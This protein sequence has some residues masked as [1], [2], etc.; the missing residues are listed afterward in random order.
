MD[1]LILAAGKGTRMKN[2][3]SKVLFDIAGRPM[4]YYVIDSTFQVS[5]EKIH[6]VLGHDSENVIKKLNKHPMKNKF[7]YYIQKE[8]LG[9]GHAVMSFL[10]GIKEETDNILVLCGDTPLL[11]AEELADFK[12][13]HIKNENTV[14]VITTE[15]ASPH[16]YGRIIKDK[17]GNIKRIVEQ[18][19]A[20]CE[21]LKIKEINSGIY[22]FDFNFLKRAAFNLKSSNSQNEFYLTDLIQISYKE[23]KK[24]G[25]FAGNKKHLSGVNNIVALSEARKIIQKRINE[26]LMLAG[27]DIYSPETVYIDYDVEVENDTRI[28]P[29]TI[30][31]GKS[32]IKKDSVIGPHVFLKDSV[33]EAASVEFSH[34]EGAS[35]KKGAEA[36]PFSRLRS[37]TLLSE[38]SKVS[39]FVEIKNSTLDSNVK[40]SHLSYIGDSHIG[41]NSNIGAGT[42]TCNYDGKNKHK[43]IIGR[44]CFIGSNSTLIAPLNIGDNSFVAG[45]STINKNVPERA[46]AFGRSRQANKLNYNK[47]SS[48]E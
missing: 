27:V 45:G 2:S 23:G 5:P 29:F 37:G 7:N 3:K 18:K 10:K 21:E 9:T 15:L 32:K 14:S 28:N 39:N 34:L 25:T 6:F 40:A 33:V 11:S 31:C 19:D 41:S 36:G 1:V 16:G 20:S 22:I 35:L 4:I 13:Y 8:Q 38:D 17:Q 46:L 48:D 12:D 24:A 30:I 26:N 42:I 47:E 44:N 43:T